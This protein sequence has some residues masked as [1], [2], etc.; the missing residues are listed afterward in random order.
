MDGK[1]RENGRMG[2]VA[3]N[4]RYLIENGGNGGRGGATESRDWQ[5]LREGRGYRELLLAARNLWTWKDERGY[6]ELPL[7]ASNLRKWG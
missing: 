1:G 2:V 4:W 5:K 3:V 6:R 7:A